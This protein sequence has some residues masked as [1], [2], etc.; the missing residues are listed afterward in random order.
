[1]SNVLSALSLTSLQS[2]HLVPGS[3]CGLRL[4]T[5]VLASPVLPARHPLICIVPEF[6]SGCWV[7]HLMKLSRSVLSNSESTDYLTRV[8]WL[9]HFHLESSTATTSESPLSILTKTLKTLNFRNSLN[10]LWAWWW[11]SSNRLFAIVTTVIHPSI[12]R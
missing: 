9:S 4:K 3:R 10:I 2:F 11:L 7:Y 5:R 6:A 12:N 8:C 1:M